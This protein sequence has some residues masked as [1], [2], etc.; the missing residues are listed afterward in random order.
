MI[1]YTLPALDTLRMLPGKDDN[2]LTFY[3]DQSANNVTY[4]GF[5]YKLTWTINGHTIIQVFQPLGRYADNTFVPVKINIKDIL[6]KYFTETEENECTVP[7]QYYNGKIS[8]L[9]NLLI[10]G[11]YRTSN[12]ETVIDSSNPINS[13]SPVYFYNGE[14]FSFWSQKNNS[15]T[16]SNYMATSDRKGTWIG[17]FKPN[18]LSSVNPSIGR[19]ARI[20]DVYKREAYDM[21]LTSNRTASTFLVNGTNVNNGLTYSYAT[22]AVYDLKG[23]VSRFGTCDLDVGFVDNVVSKS[24]LTVPVGISQLND[25]MI[26]SNVPIEPGKFSMQYYVYDGVIPAL[27]ISPEQDSYYQ[28]WLGNY[29]PYGALRTVPLTFRI[30]PICKRDTEMEY[31][32]SNI[33]DLTILYYSRMGGW[34]QIPL[35]SK[36]NKRKINVKNTLRNSAVIS[37]NIFDRNKHVVTTVSDEKYLVNTGWL[38]DREVLEVEDMLQSPVL[39][40]ISGEKYIPVVI[41]SAD[42][43]IDTNRG[44]KSYSF[45]FENGY[46]KNTIR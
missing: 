36:R 21:D 24:I 12:G 9:S 44:L 3:S 2:I 18:G 5:Y 42:V 1:T 28:I 20:K 16:A 43:D 14:S 15:T 38:N 31:D 37:K 23:R 30:T 40:L 6:D 27:E 45:E 25:I 32:F 22:L 26:W 17:I 10:Q 8:T 41:S 35:Y 46:Y 34:W 7:T 33:S 11:C 29:V 39:W 13:A 4:P 19:G